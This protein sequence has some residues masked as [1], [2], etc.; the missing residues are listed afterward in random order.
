[1][2]MTHSEKA[3]ELF[4][5]GYNC[6]QSVMAAFCDVTGM[7]TETALMLSSSFG[8]GMGC[9]REVCGACSSMFMIA[10]L[11]YGYDSPDDNAVKT[12]HYKLIQRLAG[13]FKAEHG[14]VICRE[15]LKNLS[16]AKSSVPEER[17][18]KYYKV[19]PCVKFVE[20]AANILDKYISE[21]KDKI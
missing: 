21:S 10:G 12:E 1:M 14:S 20:S 9:M 19:R 6:A 2:E 11:L 7:D 16:A 5:E 18:E 17:T 3:T 13:E 8:A 4:A 15:L